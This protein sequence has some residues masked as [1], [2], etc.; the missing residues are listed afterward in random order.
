MNYDEQESVDGLNELGAIGNTQIDQSMNM[1]NVTSADLKPPIFAEIQL[2]THD[3]AAFD[4]MFSD[5][6]MLSENEMQ[7]DSIPQNDSLESSSIVSAQ[8]NIPSAVSCEP[9]TGDHAN[10][11]PIERIVTGRTITVKID[12]DLECTFIS[13]ADFRPNIENEYQMKK[14]DVLCHNRPFKQNVIIAQ[15]N[16]RV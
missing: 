5:E 7:D 12:D 11:V 15:R 14:E 4:A 9:Q 10:R 13:H 1:A 6:E 2:P 16:G 3:A 8:N